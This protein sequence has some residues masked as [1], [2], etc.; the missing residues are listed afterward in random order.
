MKDIT[1]GDQLHERLSIFKGNEF[2]KDTLNN[3]WWDLYVRSRNE[4]LWETIGGCGP[5][6]DVGAGFGVM[7]TVDLL[8]ETIG[9]AGKI[10]CPGSSQDSQPV[11]A[12][13]L[14]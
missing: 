3:A 5:T 2:A 7:E 9:Q 10:P 6:I 4:P 12:Y 11:L 8:I 14:K 1:S 13:G